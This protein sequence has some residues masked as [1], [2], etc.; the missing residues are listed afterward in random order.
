MNNKEVK[1][2]NALVDVIRGLAILIV[3]LGHTISYNNIEGYENSIIFKV[4]WSLQMPLF[5]VISGYI[6][7]YSR[8]PNS[9][10][11][12]IMYIA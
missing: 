8:S 11:S 6:T 1:H 2:R 4:I 10:K 9:S 7:K 12:L 3:I 5:M